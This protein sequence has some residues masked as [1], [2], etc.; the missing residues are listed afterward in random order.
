MRGM[1]KG[2][3]S[4]KSS[5]LVPFTAPQCDI[6][7]D[8]GSVTYK[9]LPLPLSH[10]MPDRRPCNR[11]CNPMGY[12][13]VRR[14]GYRYL[15]HCSLQLMTDPDAPDPVDPK[16]AEFL[17]WLV[18]DVPNGAHS[19]NADAKRA[20]TAAIISQGGPSCTLNH[21]PFFGRTST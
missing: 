13:I 11:A 14:G 18:T 5:E 4:L 8:P 2:L 10:A 12:Y 17:H 1:L 6:S 9:A 21:L 20:L 3:F 16:W 7:L 15:V 19:C